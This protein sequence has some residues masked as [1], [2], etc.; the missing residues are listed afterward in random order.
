MNHMIAWVNTTAWLLWRDLSV[1]RKNI[2]NSFIDSL[3]MP[4][5]MI[6]I[7]GYILPSLGLPLTYGG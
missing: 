6:V 2:L 5:T 7:G 1:L 3:I 4:L